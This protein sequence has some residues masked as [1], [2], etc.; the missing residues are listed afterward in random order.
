MN[1]D[2]EWQ[3]KTALRS[4]MSF[5]DCKLEKELYFSD[6]VACDHHGIPIIPFQIN[7]GYREGRREGL[8]EKSNGLNAANQNLDI[9]TLVF[10]LS[11]RR[12][13]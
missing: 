12:K 13:A 11:K 7:T 4:P 3:E 5:K 9:E 2:I 1:L 10:S 8:P 6:P